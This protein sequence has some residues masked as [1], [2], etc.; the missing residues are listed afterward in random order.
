MRHTKSAAVSLG[1]KSPQILSNPSLF[2]SKL[3]IRSQSSTKLQPSKSA[4]ETILIEA[5][6][7]ALAFSQNDELETERQC[8]QRLQQISNKNRSAPQSVRAKSSNQNSVIQGQN[9]RLTKLVFPEELD[10]IRKANSLASSPCP[11]FRQ[12]QYLRSRLSSRM[13][14]SQLTFHADLREFSPSLPD[15]MAESI[16][17]LF[18]SKRKNSAKSQ[19]YKTFS[20]NFLKS[21]ELK[22]LPKLPPDINFEEVMTKAV[23]KAQT[24]RIAG[25]RYVSGKWEKELLMQIENNEFDNLSPKIKIR[26]VNTHT[27]ARHI[28]SDRDIQSQFFGADKINDN[29]LAKYSSIQLQN[30]KKLISPVQIDHLPFYHELKEGAVP[31]TAQDGQRRSMFNESLIRLFH[32]NIQNKVQQNDRL[33]RASKLF[34]QQIPEDYTRPAILKLAGN[35]RRRKGGWFE[36]IDLTEKKVD[37]EEKV[38]DVVDQMKDHEHDQMMKISVLQIAAPTNPLELKGSKPTDEKLVSAL[39]KGTKKLRG[40][41][42]RNFKK[43]R[44]NLIEA[45]HNLARLGLSS[46]D[47]SFFFH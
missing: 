30:V 17:S 28:K 24:G 4:S 12:S 16:T 18:T 15:S 29:D 31:S 38:V 9:D 32:E 21:K 5:K 7:P 43:I 2:P 44:Q 1:R 11:S 46:E 22:D 37:L 35:Y 33:H 19:N 36:G 8:S 40:D 25:E 23:K 13:T 20:E 3:T 39:K 41:V 10:E 6:L 34:Q 45:L 14:G 27:P 42:K 47:V 26:K